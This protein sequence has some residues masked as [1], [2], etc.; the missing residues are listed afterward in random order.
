MTDIFILDKNLKQGRRV[1]IMR[2]EG[3]YNKYFN[4]EKELENKFVLPREECK[5]RLFDFFL[6]N[7]S[8]L[9]SSGIS[10]IYFTDDG[11]HFI[12]PITTPEVVDR[13]Y[14]NRN[15]MKDP[16]KK[17]GP[18]GVGSVSSLEY[19]RLYGVQVYVLKSPK[20]KKKKVVEEKPKKKTKGAVFA[21]PIW[22]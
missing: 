11:M 16:V 20:E 17:H 14:I 22:D 2:S 8:T 18:S 21:P 15:L 6:A 9:G 10:I 4:D 3:A 5:K 7:A 1:T 13:E 19:R 12:D